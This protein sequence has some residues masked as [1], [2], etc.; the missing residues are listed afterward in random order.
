V[1]LPGG[2]GGADFHPFVKR[3]HKHALTEDWLVAQLVAVKW[4]PEQQ[5]VWPT[6]DNPVAEQEFTSEEF[7]AAVVEDVAGRCKLDDRRTFLLAWSSGGPAAYA[8]SLQKK[9]PVTGSFIA[10][11]VFKPTLLPSLEAAKGHAYF[12]Y[13]S[14]DDNVCPFRIAKSAELLLR[15]NKAEVELATYEGGHGWHG[16]VYGS[17]RKGIEWLDAA[18]ER[19]DELPETAG[20]E[21][22]GSM[23][24]SDD[25]ETGDGAPDGWERGALVDGVEY[26]WDRGTASRG[27]ASLCLRKT[28]QRFVPIAQWFRTAPHEHA[29]SRLRVSAKV[30]A[31]RAAKAV[32]DVQFLDGRGQTLGHEWAAYIGARNA[33]DPPADHDWREYSGFV[34]IPSGAEAIRVGLQIYG[35][36]TVWFDE[37]SVGYVVPATGPGKTE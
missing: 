29:S 2:D 7:V 13:H 16:D 1:V 19:A 4:T 9:R 28:A 36:G 31:Q 11:S 33:G 37:L 21:A 8:V 17:I 14:P 5:I 23:L 12:L 32:I 6:R 15:M 30:R 22:S 35:P 26:I 3:I 24:I 25:F 27:Q 34:Y 20:A 10:M 18:V